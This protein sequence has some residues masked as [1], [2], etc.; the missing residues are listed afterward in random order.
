MTVVVFDEHVY[1]EEYQ[2]PRPVKPALCGA[3]GGK[4]TFV[5]ST[6]RLERVKADKSICAECRRKL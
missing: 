4:P 1:L 6:S 2:A 5:W 3:L